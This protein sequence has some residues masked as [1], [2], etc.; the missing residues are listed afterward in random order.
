[1][2]IKEFHERIMKIMKI[3]EF[4]IGIIKTNG[5]RA[6]ARAQF[7]LFTLAFVDLF[8]SGGGCGGHGDVH[9]DNA[10]H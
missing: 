4:R 8:D 5:T 6:Q 2:K 10:F 1:M 3:L 7:F 9:G